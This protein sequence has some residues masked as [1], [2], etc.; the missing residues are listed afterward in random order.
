[1]T[2]TRLPK[3]FAPDEL[4]RLYSAASAR[5]DV[6]AAMRFLHETGLRIAE[7]CAISS[8]EAGAW[9]H[10]PRWCRRPGCRRHG[11]VVLRVIGKGDRERV[12]ILTPAA[13]RSARVLLSHTSNGRL[14]PWT[15]RG[16]RFLFDQ[17]GRAA[18]VHC[19]PHRFRHSYAS[20][21]VE[22]GVPIE[23]VADML[24][25][26][27]VEITRLYWVASE[28]AKVAALARRRRWLRRR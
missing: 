2:T 9:P 20:E 12:V 4:E 24:G 1:M 6:A 11:R 5:P 26:S 3:P 23:V 13:L 16:V 10:P 14:M 15:D 22:S 27:T 25:H 17:V 28:R 21:L 18:G 7:A 8:A 19:F